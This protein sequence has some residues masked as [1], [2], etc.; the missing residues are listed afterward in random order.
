[1]EL[2]TIEDVGDIYNDFDDEEEEV[3]VISDDDDTGEA[4]AL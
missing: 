1:M 3:F 2:I 4:E